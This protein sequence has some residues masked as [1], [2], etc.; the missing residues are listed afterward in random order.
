MKKTVITQSTNW[1]LEFKGKGRDIMFI[2]E[3][4]RNLQKYF[5]DNPKDIHVART[6]VQLVSRRRKLLHYLNSKDNDFCKQIVD[7]LA[8]SKDF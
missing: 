5:K 8:S 4:I 3:K 1:D 2:S 7:M 6:I